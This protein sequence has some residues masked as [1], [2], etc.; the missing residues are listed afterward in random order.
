MAIQN[1]RDLFLYQLCAM[2]DIE[3]KL[4]QM[5]PIL[6]Q[7]SLDAQAREAFMQHE[8]ETRQHISNL[9]QCF[10]M[11]GSQPLIVENYMVAGLRRDHDTFLQ[12]QPP[13][14]ALSMF[15]LYI[16]YQ[17]ESLEIAGYHN[18]I[19][20]ANSI[21]LSQ[22]VPLLQQNLQQEIA[23]SQKLA[24]LAH[25][26]GLQQT[27]LG[28][29]PVPNQPVSNQPPAGANQPMPNQ[30]PQVANQPMPNQPSQAANQ[31]VPNQGHGTANP[32]VSNQPPM[33]PDPPLMNQSSGIAN[34]SIAD[35]PTETANA[36]AANAASQVREG[37]DVVGSD[38]RPVG[39]VRN[40]RDNDFRIDIPMQRDLYAPFDAVQN[41][42]ADRVIL[43]I[44][45][46]QVRDMNWSKPSL[47]G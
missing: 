28:Q 3:R 42:T 16:G 21:G 6:A 8:Q 38:M 18:L 23:A 45:A 25:Q 11:L 22:C 7:E 15:D 24:A 30:S 1:P 10:Q 39:V 37:M 17:S 20:A 43:N 41:V 44:P 26:L 36:P 27:Q 14:Q 32:P 47:M 12:Q 31:P 5:L 2:Y 46:D 4:D 9:E 34:P 29:A 33:A 35:E 13:A 40:V 19:D